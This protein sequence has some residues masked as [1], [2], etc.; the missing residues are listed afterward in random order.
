M[1]TGY[2]VCSY[3][4]EFRPRILELQRHLWGS[5][6]NL[7]D[8]YFRWKYERNPYTTDIRVYLAFEGEQAVGMR[9]FFGSRWEA[10]IPPEAVSMWCADDLVVLPEHRNRG[11]FTTIMNA[12]FEDVAASLSGFALNLGGQE[13]TVLGSLTM[14]WKSI[15]SVRPLGRSS[16]HYRRLYDWRNHLAQMPLLWRT[17]EF[18]W[19][20]LVSRFDRLDAWSS[21]ESDPRIAIRVA[22]EPD[23]QGMVSLVKQLDYDGR[24]RH[25]R[26]AQ[27]LS[28]RFQN[29][30][31][32]YR[33]LYAG[34]SELT[35]YIV[36]HRSRPDRDWKAPIHISDFEANSPEVAEALL[37]TALTAGK[38][39][40]ITAWGAALPAGANELLSSRGFRPS[41]V[42]RT[43]RG[44][45]CGLVRPLH[46]VVP[47]AQ[48]SIGGKHLLDPGNWDLRMLYSM[49]G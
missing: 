19:L 13:L 48:W 6:S 31:H 17:T 9:G 15:G 49:V 4:P 12:A 40:A 1:T 42:V 14:G 7:N 34:G 8:A 18:R 43:A 21:S 20:N 32:E 41:Q 44:T 27:Y 10:G 45:N 37:D 46:A 22:A 2:R 11:L 25:V 23:V 3:R 47:V 28:W 35:G 16:K 38:F 5:N 36:L 30:L 29:P 39:P 26:D 24:I 33:F